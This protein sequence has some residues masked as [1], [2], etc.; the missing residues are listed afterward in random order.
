LRGGE[1][2]GGTLAGAGKHICAP[3][4]A[5]TRARTAGLGLSSASARRARE[6]PKPPGAHAEGEQPRKRRTPLP[7]RPP[8]HGTL[9]AQVRCG[10]DAAVRL[11]RLRAGRGPLPRPASPGKRGVCV[12]VCVCGMRVSA[13]HGRLC[14]RACVRGGVLC[15]RVC[16]IK[17]TVTGGLRT[18]LPSGPQCSRRSNSR[19][20]PRAISDAHARRAVERLPRAPIALGSPAWRCCAPRTS[21]LARVR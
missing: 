19:L 9:Y 6:R 4:A 14:V 13:M 20:G 12:C 7:R 2:G 10:R 8:P 16:P 11:V 1:G 18:K 3:T 15:V 21:R 17:S 5:R